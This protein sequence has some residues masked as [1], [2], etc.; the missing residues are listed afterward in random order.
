MKSIN[1]TEEE[2][3]SLSYDDVAEIILENVGKKMK[4]QDLFKEVIKVMNLSESAFE[5]HLL[6]F[7][8]LLSTDKRFIMIEKGYW[9]LKINHS[10][11]LIIDEE[12]EEEEII[13]EELEEDN[14]EELEE[15]INYDEEILDD[16]EDE[17][18]LKDLVIMDENEENELM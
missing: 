9:D 18:E 10:T 8:E 14:E 4:T 16:D 7:F 15:E 12:D 11:K 6:D 5:E 1:L 2:L 13:E 17:D 3:E